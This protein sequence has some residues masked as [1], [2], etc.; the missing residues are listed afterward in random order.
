MKSSVRPGSTGFPP[1][2]ADLVENR[3]RLQSV[4]AA[5]VARLPLQID[6]G[7]IGEPPFTKGRD[8][9]GLAD[10]AG[11]ADQQ[12]PA[13]IIPR[14]GVQHTVHSSPQNDP[15]TRCMT[16]YRFIWLK[17]GAFLAIKWLKN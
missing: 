17:S 1:Q 5:P 3:P 10:L 9:V 8:R 12:R 7:D 15:P 6:R 11:A 4:E 16:A 14:P 2:D 13:P